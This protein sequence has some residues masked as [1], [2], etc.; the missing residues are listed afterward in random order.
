MMSTD[1]PEQALD[2]ADM[3]G[4]GNSTVAPADDD[5]LVRMEQSDA[6][7]RLTLNQP[8]KRNTLTH[9][10]IEA[11]QA[12][13]RTGETL[14]SIRVIVLAAAGPVFSAGHDLKELQAHRS[15]ADQGAR[16][17]QTL[18]EQCGHLMAQ[19]VSMEKPVIA[20]IQ[21]VATAAGC[22]LVASCDLAVAADTA[23]FATPGVKIGLFCST[24][25]VALTR[26]VP[27]KAA[28]EMLL[29]GE[30]IAAAKAKE[31]GLIN[32]VVPLA[33]LRTETM[34]LAAEI[35]KAS[36]TV[37]AVGKVACQ[38][39]IDMPLGDAYALTSIAMAKNMAEAD[40]EEGIAAF[41]EKREPYWPSQR[42]VYDPVP[43]I[44][45]DSY[46]DD[47]LQSLLTD[48]KTIA[49]VGASDKPVRPS[50]LVMH[51]LIAR[52]YDVIPVN[53]VLAGQTVLGQTVYSSVSAIPD[54]IEI[55][56]VDVF[57]RSDKV[58]EILPE[59][60]RLPHR[61]GVLWLQLG[62]RDDALARKAEEAGICVVMD[63]CPKI[64]YGRLSGEI[65]W[66]GYNRKSIS[67]KKA[68]L[69]SHRQIRMLDGRN[70]IS[71][72]GQPEADGSLFD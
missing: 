61:P 69:S 60:L 19:I 16:F 4:G 38:A 25:M 33:D 70:N 14:T 3:V 43:Q 63:R 57:R 1:G 59:I 29:T 6:V 47:Y 72:T 37:L 66:I 2:R 44:D 52:G 39:Q 30:M 9:D 18:F 50:Y 28:M 26:A 48:T 36:A 12:A 51:Y 10:M 71:Q 11:L 23:R 68:K 41:L 32:R 34:A 67:S 13:L 55:D 7:L 27:R 62:V 22:Q 54:H 40:C 5:A 46:S 45:H 58:A 53:P 42:P 24:P 17:Y 20:E 64:E 49:L 21:G 31:I 56:M 8:D 15:D 65:N 35:A